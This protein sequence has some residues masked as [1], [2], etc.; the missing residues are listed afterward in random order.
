MPIPATRLVTIAQAALDAVVAGFAAESRAL[1]ARQFVAPGTPAA[2]PFDCELLAVQLTRTFGQEGNVA[3]PAAQPV[4]AHPGF[5]LRGCDIAVT[6]VRCVP[7]IQGGS[8]LARPRVP[9]APVEQAAAEELLTDA[10]VLTNALLER[11]AFPVSC[12]GVI[13]RDW[14][15][16]GP[17][18]GF[19]GGILNVT[20]ALA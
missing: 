20:V 17:A 9:T 16:I 2:L 13:V 19:G 7:E 1:P 3:S 12:N 11:G 6:L 5:A 10:V 18:G 14:S 4:F 8:S 15:A